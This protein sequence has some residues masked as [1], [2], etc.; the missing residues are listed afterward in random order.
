MSRSL[1]ITKKPGWLVAGF[2]VTK[3][4]EPATKYEY[5]QSV[6]THYFGERCAGI[7]AKC[8]V[9]G[10]H[11]CI[12]LISKTGE[13][14]LLW[15]AKPSEK[16][17]N[18]V[19]ETLASPWFLKRHS[20]PSHWGFATSK[21]PTSAVLPLQRILYCKKLISITVLFTED[22]LHFS[23]S[24]VMI[25]VDV[26]LFFYWC[27]VSKRASLLRFWGNV[28]FPSVRTQVLTCV[29]AVWVCNH[30]LP[31]YTCD[32]FCSMDDQQLSYLALSVVQRLEVLTT[33]FLE[34]LRM[35]EC[36]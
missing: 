2:L 14:G 32:I 7:K 9:L 8:S 6:A 11:W 20:R 25:V 36:N 13:V 28:H 19:I 26:V 15:V 10:T 5:V 30:F 34:T 23:N 12:F 18:D 29:Q 33:N 35:Q 1:K 17:S 21:K 16:V 3:K 27:R 22:Y 4:P 24:I 31:M